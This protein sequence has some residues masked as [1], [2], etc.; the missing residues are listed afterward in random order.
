MSVNTTDDLR[1]ELS[2]V[3]DGL[4]AG[5]LDRRDAALINNTVGKFLAVGRYEMD[6]VK[7]VRMGVKL[8]G[9][10]ISSVDFKELKPKV[11]NLVHAKAKK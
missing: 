6:V 4:K 5:T 8:K 10:F 11:K 3:L 9:S 1:R 2:G 7:L